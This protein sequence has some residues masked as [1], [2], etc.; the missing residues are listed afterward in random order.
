MPPDPQSPL[1]PSSGES[2]ANTFRAGAH[3]DA[4]RRRS[5][6]G[7]SHEYQGFGEGVELLVRWELS[8]MTDVVSPCVSSFRPAARRSLKGER[9]HMRGIR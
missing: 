5:A 7:E 4:R 6:G 1:E 2:V 8:E 3:A 9:T